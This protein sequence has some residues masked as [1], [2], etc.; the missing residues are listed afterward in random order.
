MVHTRYN[1]ICGADLSSGGK[2][3]LRRSNNRLEFGPP[4]SSSE[5]GMR[6]FETMLLDHSYPWPVLTYEHVIR[7]HYIYIYIYM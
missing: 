4:K 1:L 7:P 2:S 6:D 3:T 5:V